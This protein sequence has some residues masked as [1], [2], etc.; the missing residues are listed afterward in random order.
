MDA[1]HLIALALIAAALPMSVAICC[2][3]RRAREAAFFLMAVST[4]LAARFGVEFASQYWYRGTTRG[5]EIT[6]I[7][8]LAVG[9]LFSSLLLPRPGQARWFWP[10]SLGLMGL[11]LVY[12]S[13]SVAISEP[14]LY[15]LFELSKI[16]RGMLVF[17]AAAVFVRSEREL[18]LLVLALGCA[19]CFEA[20]LALKQRYLNGVYR[21]TG[22]LDH[23]NS[24]SMFLC[25]SAPVLVA[26]ATSNFPRWVRY[27]S[28]L[29]ITAATVSVLLTVSRAGIP[30]FGLVVLGATAA[31]AS[32][33]I[34]FKK[35]LATMLIGVAASALV[36]KSW[37][38]IK[39]RFGEATLREE[40]LDENVEG[41]GMY[42]RLAWAIVSERPLGVGLN[43]WSYWVSKSYGARL[44]LKYEDYDDIEASPS[45]LALPSI[46]YAAPAHSL[47]ALTVG[48]LG[49]PG[50]VLFA[51]MWLRWFGMG[52]GF[53]FKRSAD[54]MLRI[55]AGLCFSVGGVF[56][57]SLTEWT[58]R[59]T[60]IFL[61][62]SI[63]LGALASLHHIKRNAH[64][65]ERQPPASRVAR[66]VNL[67][68]AGASTAG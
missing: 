10:A 64:R 57:Q 18:K 49:W 24:L 47:G 39:A 51:L 58:Y 9:V 50:L 68:L 66:P 1:K 61:M 44:D 11:Y 55:G 33:R 3:S 30:I 25:M 59:Q 45:K 4:V 21:V 16:L 35:V 12:A 43:N 34:T 26:A 19:I 5:F 40:Y 65:T 2:I 15:G 42:L 60:A 32:W 31:C 46:H 62:S 20:A 14:K 7:D 53:V 41:R 63:L 13:F 38:T 37:S 36:Y 27:F 23:P 67:E 17:V 8:I 56:L 52:A 54:V 29:C 28:F 6:V 48:E 22:S